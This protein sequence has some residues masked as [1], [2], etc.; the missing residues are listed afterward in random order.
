MIHQL[1]GAGAA[2][3]LAGLVFVSV[4][5]NL[6][7]VL[8]IRGL[9]GRAGESIVMSVGIRS[10]DGLRSRREPVDVHDRLDE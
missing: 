3:V 6:E 5:I 9:P 8:A 7:R 4:S 1:S 2:T 10:R